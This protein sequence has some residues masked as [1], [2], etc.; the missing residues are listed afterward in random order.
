MDRDDG[1]QPK[2]PKSRLSVYLPQEIYQVVLRKSRA[3]G[4]TPEE[5]VVLMLEEQT[6]LD[7]G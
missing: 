7:Q 4:C 6:S 5:A 1:S 2:R 3:L